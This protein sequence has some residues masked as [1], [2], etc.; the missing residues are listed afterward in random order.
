MFS[1]AKIVFYFVYIWS[2]LLPFFL[3]SA[4]FYYCILGNKIYFI[5]TYMT[6]S[7]EEKEKKSFICVYMSDKEAPNVTEG[8][9][10]ECIHAGLFCANSRLRHHNQQLHEKEPRLD[11]D[12]VHIFIS[13]HFN[14]EVGPLIFGGAV[15]ISHFTE[16]SIYTVY[17][18]SLQPMK[19]CRFVFFIRIIFPGELP[20]SAT[21]DT[22]SQL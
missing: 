11:V 7:A 4:S 19:N 17:S 9:I 10:R 5:K 21:E 12:D 18:R 3:Q 6:M 20:N 13:Q 2:F 8:Q 1:S 16:S 15:L 14:W 22:T